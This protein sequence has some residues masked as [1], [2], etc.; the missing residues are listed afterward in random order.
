MRE[1]GAIDVKL[2]S[3]RAL[4]EEVAPPSEQVEATH[5]GYDGWKRAH[6]KPLHRTG[7]SLSKAVGGGH[8]VGVRPDTQAICLS[9]G[10]GTGLRRTE[11]S[12]SPILAAGS[13]ASW[14]RCPPS[15]FAANFVPSRANFGRLSSC[16]YPRCQRRNPNCCRIMHRS[17]VRLP[18]VGSSSDTLCLRFSW[19][20]PCLCTEAPPL[21]SATLTVTPKWVAATSRYS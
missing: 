2:A 3:T 12:R 1:T 10:G 19:L 5:R 18:R 4:P 6:A 14:Q 21:A 15:E 20:V 7:R 11:R 9:I 8:G 13:L 16:R 17:A